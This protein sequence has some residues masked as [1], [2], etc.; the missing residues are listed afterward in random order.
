MTKKCVAT[1]HAGEDVD[2]TTVMVF[3]GRDVA[4]FGG[5]RNVSI[6]EPEIRV[7]VGCGVFEPPT[8]R[9]LALAL[10]EVAELAFG[11]GPAG[12]AAPRPAGKKAKKTGQGRRAQVVRVT[13]VSTARLK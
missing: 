2:G 11:D 1:R 4:V 9:R 13:G 5:G 6:G 3:L 8:A 12:R 10:G 7:Q